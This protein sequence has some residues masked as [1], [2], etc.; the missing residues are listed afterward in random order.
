MEISTVVGGP[1]GVNSYI[2]Y[3]GSS[4][5]IIDPADYNKISNKLK[6]LNLKLLAVLLTHGHFDHVWALK[7]YFNALIF[8]FTFMRKI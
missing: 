5:V 4:S 8:L 3:D 6:E 2:V 7:K 1:G